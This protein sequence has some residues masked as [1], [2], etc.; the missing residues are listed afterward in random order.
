MSGPAPWAPCERCG[1][2]FALPRHVH[3]TCEE[4]RGDRV[5]DPATQADIDEAMAALDVA[6]LALSGGRIN[7]LKT[8][9]RAGIVTVVDLTRRAEMH[10]GKFQRLRS[11]GYKGWRDGSCHKVQSKQSS[12]N[13]LP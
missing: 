1:M 6:T 12:G 8:A 4:E 9:L 7:A 5:P 2:P 10:D 3:H 11:Q 13:V